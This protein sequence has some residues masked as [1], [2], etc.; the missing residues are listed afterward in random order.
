MDVTEKWNGTVKSG[1]GAI[2]NENC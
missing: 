2:K 1:K